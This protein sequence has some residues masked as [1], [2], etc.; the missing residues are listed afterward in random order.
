MTREARDAAGDVH[1]RMPA[2]LDDEV[3][4]EWIAPGKLEK[5][6]REHLHGALGEVSEKIART[7]VTH[8]VDRAVNNVRTLDRSDSGLIAPIDLG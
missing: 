4:R 8:P 2:F 6:E 7:L 5:D 3:M 1:D